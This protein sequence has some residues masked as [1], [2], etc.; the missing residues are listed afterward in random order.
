[1]QGDS[2]IEYAE[3]LAVANL[4]SGDAFFFLPK[5]LANPVV[6]TIPGQVPAQVEGKLVQGYNLIG[7]G[8][9][10]DFVLNGEVAGFGNMTNFWTAAN[11]FTRNRAQGSADQIK[12]Y[13]GAGYTDYWLHNGK[14]STAAEKASAGI[15]V[16]QGD[17]G[18]VQVSEAIPADSG[19]FFIKYAAG[20][21]DFKPPMPYSL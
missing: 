4:K 19:F 3:N 6:I 2:S 20:E 18:I 16:Y 21:I 15:W 1:M 14:G 9:P 13:N 11:G 7:S 17:D 10:T 5:Q 12:V 8:M